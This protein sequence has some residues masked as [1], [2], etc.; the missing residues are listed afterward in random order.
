MNPANVRLILSREIRDQLRDRRTLFMVFVLPI[1]LYPLLGISLMQM[2][3]FRTERPMRVL[4]I[5]ADSLWEEAADPCDPPLF[6]GGQF[7]PGLC[8]GW[9]RAGDPLELISLAGQ[10]DTD[11]E[12]LA[13]Q[14]RRAVQAGQY[15]AALQ[16]PADFAE[17]LEAQRRAIRR[18]AATPHQGQPARGAAAQAGEADHGPPAVP[19]PTVLYTTANERS[20]IAMARLSAALDRWT[21]AVGR[22]NL[23]TT[24]LPATTV[25]PFEVDTSDV[26]QETAYQGAAFWSKILPI[27]LVVWA[28]TGAFYP[29]VD[30][31]AGEKERGTLETLL[32]S[33][34]E[35]SEIVLGKL[36]CVMAFSSATAVLNLLSVGATGWL[37][38]SRVAD[39]YPPPPLAPL[40]LA[41]ALLPVSALFSAL[42]VALAAFARSSKEGQYYLVPLMLITLPLAVVPMTSG[43]ELAL[44]N[45]LIPIA[46]L[47]LL[48]KGLLEGAY[49]QV[50][51]LLPVVLAVTAAA[52]WLA[53]RWAVEQFNSENVL[54]HEGERLEV[55]LWLRRL[56]RDRQATPTAAAAVLCGVILLVLRFAAQAVLPEPASFSGLACTH[57]AMQLALILAPAVLLTALLA[58]NPRRTLLLTLPRWQTLAAAAALAVTLQPVG[59]ALGDGIQRLYP[60]SPEIQESLEHYQAILARGGAGAIVL[61]FAFLPAVCEELACRGFILSGFRRLGHRWRAIVA[62][63]ALFGLLHGLLQQSILACLL[64]IVLG[65]LAVQT[66]SILPGILFHFLYNTLILAATWT[67]AAW[68]DHWPLL[69]FVVRRGADGAVTCPWPVLLLGGLASAALLAWFARLPCVRSPEEELQAAIRAAGSEPCALG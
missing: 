28:M 43:T 51:P 4:L 47:V 65:Y 29:A 40:W 57:L 21:E 11:A 2:K 26:A 37:V 68:L 30:L 10:A 32:S 62:S 41:A 67:T 22:R 59:M 42:C 34:A 48:L 39:S 7:A 46:G 35:R 23:E 63:A 53:I 13:E 14:A 5:G 20:R 38:F 44:G 3:Q 50:L 52:C 45:S 64:G 58:G 69:R 9:D 31:C 61:L 36:L 27:L 55:R 19:R 16:F 12:A 25:R 60:V 6:E 15:D 66:A 17:R 49:A 18:W 24:Q 8:P 1:L 33:P 54:F 56:L